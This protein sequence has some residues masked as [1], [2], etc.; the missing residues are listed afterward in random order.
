MRRVVAIG[1]LLASSARA[2][3]ASLHGT[4]TGDVAATDNVFAVASDAAVGPQADVYTQV[5]PGLLFAYDAPRMIH[6]LT[7]EVELLDSFKVGGKPSVTFR[8]GWRAFFL[9][10]P[11]SELLLAANGSTG[12]LNALTARTSPDQTGVGVLPAGRTDVRQ[13]DASELLSWASSKETRTSQTAFVRWTAT[14]DTVTPPTTTQS[15][16]VGASGGFERTFDHDTLG[17]DLGG[18]FLRLERI[19]P[20]GVM[21]GARLDQQLNP[22]ASVVYRHD[23][24]REWS[25]N[26]DGGVVYV[27]PVGTDTYNPTDV[28]HATLY[29]VVGGLLAYTDVWGRATFAARRAVTPNLYL[30]QN[31]VS[32]SAIAQLAL[33][34]PWLDDNPHA[35]MP[36]LVALGSV[37][38]ERTRLVDPS[39]ALATVFHVARADVGLGWTP[40]PGQTYGLRYEF[41]Y[42]TSNQQTQQSY[43][44]DTVFF[45]FALTYPARLGTT[46]PRRGASVR[47]DRQDLAPIGAEPVVSD[48][49]E[50]GESAEPR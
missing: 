32:D 31:T 8:G 26:V 5:R 24:N 39:G 16:E 10:G 11:R 14:S 47:S 43:H 18:S 44:R 45:T 30:A 13:A 36:K 49:A 25:S 15:L 48:P 41:V 2:D 38:V 34:L 6:E 28:R 7:A 22:R 9:P 37:G 12:Q 3:H 23:F 42:Q 27:N 50:G 46:V 21:P 35:R 1:C 20:P 4:A 19:P 29:P 33:P 17:F 40:R